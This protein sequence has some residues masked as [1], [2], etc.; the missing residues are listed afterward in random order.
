MRLLGQ[1]H[2]ISPSGSQSVNEKSA[3]FNFFQTNF[4]LLQ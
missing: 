3:K 2:L 4:R 1:M